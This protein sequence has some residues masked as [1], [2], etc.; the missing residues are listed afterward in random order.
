[1]AKRDE[2]QLSPAVVAVTPPDRKRC[3]QCK[4]TVFQ[5]PSMR[6]EIVDGQFL[7][8]ETLYACV[9]CHAVRPMEQLESFTLVH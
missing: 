5:G 7:V 2:V 3:P 9:T 6:G 4:A 1:M 8:R